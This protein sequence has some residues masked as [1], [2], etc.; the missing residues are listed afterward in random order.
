MHLQPQILCPRPLE[1]KAQPIQKR[2]QF[3]ERDRE[4]RWL[5]WT[6]LSLD[7]IASCCFWI[8]APPLFFFSNTLSPMHRLPIAIS[9]L[10]LLAESLAA[11][12]STS[13]SSSAVPSATITPSQAPSFLP[14][15]PAPVATSTIDSNGFSDDSRQNQSQI[16]WLQQH[17]R[18]VFVLI[19]GLLVVG[20]IIYYI[21]RG[22]LRARRE[23]RAENEKL[24]TVPMHN[25]RVSSASLPKYEEA[26]A[27]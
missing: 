10:V 25:R 24:A 21:V 9:L 13:L 12:A 3:W 8:F 14:P 7:T 19:L 27:Y 15:P 11:V 18:W 6:T 4:K 5:L 1:H 16:P 17:N 23:L 2:L 22:I 26:T 20:V